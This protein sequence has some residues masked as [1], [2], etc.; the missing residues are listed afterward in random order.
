MGYFTDGRNNKAVSKVPKIKQARLSIKNN[1]QSGAV[2]VYILVAI[3]LFASLSY[4]VSKDNRGSSDIFTEEQAKLAAQEIIEYGNTVAAAVQKLR[5]RGCSDTE[6][7]FENNIT[8]GYVNGTDTSCQVFHQDGGNI[9]HQR[10]IERIRTADASNHDTRYSGGSN[11]INVGSTEPELFVF[12]RMNSKDI[13][14]A[15]NNYAGIINNPD[16]PPGEVGLA[17]LGFTGTY[18]TAQTLGDD[19][20]GANLAGKEYGCY[21]V[22][23]NLD[24]NGNK[25][26]DYYH[27]LLAR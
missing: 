5:L 6:I 22:I 7:S 24:S 1:K 21:E 12:Y 23:G 17:G 9:N 13:C 26:Y 19:N 11:I 8:S 25:Q 18:L 2:F 20:D 10:I 15:I 3:A 16:S 14:I 27:V 4:F